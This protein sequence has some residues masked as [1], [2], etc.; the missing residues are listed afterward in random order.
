MRFVIVG[1]GTI[2]LSVAR[3]LMRQNHEVVLVENDTKKIDE[4]KDRIDCGLIHGDGSKPMVLREIDPKRADMLLCLTSNDQT[5]ILAS[6]VGRS[7]GYPR[8]MTRIEDPEFEHICIE[9]GLDETI[10]PARTI[11]RVLF[12]SAEGRNVLE[13]TTMLRD[14]ARVFSFV[15][16]IE[17]TLTIDELKLPDQSRVICFYRNGDFC[18]PDDTTKLR[19]EDE[20][21]LITHV[22]NLEKL[23]QQWCTTV[24][25]PQS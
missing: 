15:L 7:L 10:I 1:A 19:A 22:K 3:L 16:R 18:I 9:L 23:N 20:V 12:D 11:A 13:M 14:V 8:I 5:N 21:V 24:G 25:E 6:L 2:G 17:G 4:L